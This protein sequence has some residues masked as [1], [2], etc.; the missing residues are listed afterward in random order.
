MPAD[1][2][3]VTQVREQKMWKP[4]LLYKY[5]VGG[6]RNNKVSVCSVIKNVVHKTRE[7]SKQANHTW[8]EGVP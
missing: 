2:K 8:K 5:C 1:N 6:Y 4:T 7:K 3:G